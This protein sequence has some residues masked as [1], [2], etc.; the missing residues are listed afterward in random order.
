MQNDSHIA[1]ESL[2]LTLPVLLPRSRL[3]SLEPI[4]VG[5]RLVESLTGYVARLAEAHHLSVAILFG[6]E[7]APLACKEYLRRAIL[8][9]KYPCRIFA[10]AFRPLARSI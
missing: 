1:C 5:T 4:G 6:Y 2:D 10:S 9:S 7:L 8:R 3:F